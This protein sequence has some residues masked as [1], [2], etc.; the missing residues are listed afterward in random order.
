[1]V[2]TDKENASVV[3]VPGQ[4]FHTLGDPLLAKLLGE[5]LFKEGLAASMTD[6][7]TLCCILR[8]LRSNIESSHSSSFLSADTDEQEE[9]VDLKKSLKF[10]EIKTQL[11]PLKGKLLELS[12]T[13]VDSM[14][15]QIKLAALDLLFSAWEFLSFSRSERELVR[16]CLWLHCL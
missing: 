16:A 7:S 14:S 10:R 4:P 11:T 9:Q 13:E 3:G 6:T 1:M 8:L 5:L 2:W 12:T 15:E